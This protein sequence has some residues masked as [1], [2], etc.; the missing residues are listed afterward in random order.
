MLN[1]R[2]KMLKRRIKNSLRSAEPHPRP[3]VV[4]PGAQRCD[5]KTRRR[6]HAKALNGGV[7]IHEHLEHLGLA[8]SKC[9]FAVHGAFCEGLGA[10]RST[11]T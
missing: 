3:A 8:A 10:P 9:G 1:R 5:K 11:I 7:R 6:R 2:T 4:N